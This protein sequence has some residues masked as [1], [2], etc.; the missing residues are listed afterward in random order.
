MNKK[1]TAAGAESDG[2]KKKKTNST[3]VCS[4]TNPFSSNNNNNKSSGGSQN[5]DPEEDQKRENSYENI[6]VDKSKVALEGY[7]RKKKNLIGYKKKYYYLEEHLLKYGDKEDKVKGYIDLSI[8]NMT[9]VQESSKY[10]TQFKVLYMDLHKG[11]QEKIKLK[12][13]NKVQRDEWVNNLANV[14]K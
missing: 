14:I 13:E 10:K 7:L 8:G 1:G 5:Q 4:V 9:K 12:A 3:T 2:K 6:T 11:R